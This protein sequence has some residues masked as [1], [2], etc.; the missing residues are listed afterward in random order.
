MTTH[1]LAA[2]R[3]QIDE[4]DT[5]IVRLLDER[6]TIARE[7]GHAKGKQAPIYQPTREAQVIQHAL[8]ISDG[9]MPSPAIQAIYKEIIASCRNLQQPLRV[10]YLGPEGTYSEEAARTH[11]GTTSEYVSCLSLADV[12]RSVET[13]QADIAVLPIE[14]S[15]EGA[16][17]QTQGLLQHMRL[18]ICGEVALPIHHQ[19]LSHASSLDDVTEIAA[20]P[21]AL[22]QCAAWLQAHMPHAQHT[23]HASNASATEYASKHPAIAAI[24]SQKAAHTYTIPILASN[25]EDAINNTTR[26]IVLGRDMPTA[27]GSDKTSLVCSVPNTPGSLSKL[28]SVLSGAG[29]NMTRLESRPAR[30]VPWDY[31][32]FIDIDGH[33][34]DGSVTAALQKLKAQATYITILGSYPKAA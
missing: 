30:N 16:V 7:V 17:H 12:V 27:T 21:Q 11:C 29:I 28:L 33:Q 24:A 20:H 9:S 5:N 2:L 15:T 6:A 26:F 4:L 34:Q 1:Q 3:K 31:V 19:L 10:A 18:Q 25:I 13:R 32:F 14:N 8:E 23:A 22:A